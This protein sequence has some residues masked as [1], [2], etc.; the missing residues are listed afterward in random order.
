MYVQCIFSYIEPPQAG[1]K[2]ILIIIA[3]QSFWL[4]N[5]TLK[6]T[7]RLN[8]PDYSYQGGRF[9]I[10]KNYYNVTWFGFLFW[11]PKLTMELIWDTNSL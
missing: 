1:M 10:I 4:V 5:I 3:K 11:F 7:V 6:V 8:Y 9:L 2:M